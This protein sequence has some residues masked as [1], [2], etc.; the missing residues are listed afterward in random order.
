ML[1]NKPNF[2]IPIGDLLDEYIDNF[3]IDF[4]QYDR[5]NIICDG[6]LRYELKGLD[7]VYAEPQYYKNLSMLNGFNN[8]F[9]CVVVMAT[10]ENN[11][12][13]GYE[14]LTDIDHIKP[15]VCENNDYN[16]YEYS[17]YD[18]DNAIYLQIVKEGL[19]L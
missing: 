2:I 13:A 11:H 1:N 17:Q 12:F 7:E 10:Y 3:E 14:I 5:E 9:Y 6:V 18:E 4:T 8:V 19:G 16:E 15:L